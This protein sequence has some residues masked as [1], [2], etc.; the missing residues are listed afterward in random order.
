M[1][2]GIIG[3]GNMAEALG[4]RWAAAGH[5][6]LFGGRCTARAEALAT[7]PAE[8]RHARGG[9]RLRRR[10][11]A[12]PAVRRRGGRPARHSARR[13]EPL[14]GRVVVDCTNAVGPASGSPPARGRGQPVRSPTPPARGSSRPSTTCPTRCGGCRRP[15]SPRA[16]RGP[17]LRRRRGGPGD[18]RDPGPGPRLRP[19]AGA[20]GS[21]GPRIWRRPRRSSWALAHRPRPPDPAAALRGGHGLSCGHPGPRRSSE[22][23]GDQLQRVRLGR[24]HW[25]TASGPTRRS[26]PTRSW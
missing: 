16:A 6:V 1:R 23:E 21:T 11:A 26:G 4:G 10:G 20:A 14:R 13:T 15:P 3:T 18:G 7:A 8:R 22:H 19:P 2:I 24:R 12:R 17:A 25:S 5:R 9:G